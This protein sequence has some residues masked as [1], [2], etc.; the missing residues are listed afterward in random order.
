M[1]LLT[2]N[3]RNKRGITTLAFAPDGLALVACAMR[4]GLVLWELPV[5]GAA[6]ALAEPSGFTP[7]ALT[8][9]ADARVVSWISG[10]VRF[11]RDRRADVAREARLTADPEAL[12]VQALGGPGE[13]LIA[14]TVER[15]VGHRLRAFVPDGTGGWTGAWTIGPADDIGGGRWLA[16]A[17]RAERF[18]TWEVPP[19]LQRLPRRVVARSTL[20]GALIAAAPVGLTNVR[21][22]V[23]APDGS[24]A[25]CFKNSSLHAWRPG[26]SVEKVRTGTL[27]HYRALAFHP[28]GRHLLAG[29]NDTTARLID[30][31]TWQ[32]VRQFAWDIGT[33]TAVAVS[34][35]GTRAAAGGA[36]AVVVWDLDL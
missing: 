35:D 18:F 11:E 24:L 32:I 6:V 23:A 19:I 16:V 20:T 4:G 15:N 21:G 3:P 25:V 5:A 33:L 7:L 27:R 34:P 17:P 30:T 13:R 12:V 22:L 31:H 9:S 29:N 36:G 10:Q 1:Q 28:D 26:G 14:R 2:S 8:F